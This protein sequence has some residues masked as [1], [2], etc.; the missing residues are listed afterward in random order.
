[1]SGPTSDMIIQ[2]L[3]VVTL[4]VQPVFLCY[5]LL[6]NSY[7][8][9][10]IAVSARMVRRRVAGHFIED[11]DF[12]DQ[13]D[14]TKPLTMI[15]PAYNEEVTIV[16]SVT[17]LIQCDYPRFEIVIVNDGSSDATLARLK[18]AFRLRRT[19]GS[20]SSIRRSSKARTW[21][22]GRCT[23][24]NA[25]ATARR[26]LGSGSSSMRSSRGNRP[27]AP[28]AVAIVRRT[29]T[30]GSSASRSIPAAST[31]SDRWRQRPASDS[32]TSGASLRANRATTDPA[33]G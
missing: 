14:L 29:G 18:T 16:D 5:F 26:T 31:R 11:L 12:I 30:T 8:L 27:A 15:V 7:T 21:R 25:S 10:L 4:V 1:M 33:S 32:R 3:I 22:G 6:Y 13:G 20:E 9:Y 2:T 19:D 17:S 28:A 23:R 24:A